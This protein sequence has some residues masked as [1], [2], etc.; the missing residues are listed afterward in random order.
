[1]DPIIQKVISESLFFSSATYFS[2]AIIEFINAPTI[3]PANTI[4]KFDEFLKKRGKANDN[5]TEIIPNTKAEMLIKL[6]LN[7]NK[8]PIPAPTQQPALTPRISG[9]TS[10]LL[11]SLNFEF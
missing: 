7:P 8:I 2:I 6:E 1:M 10:G 3:I 5:S 11:N 4:D 9:E